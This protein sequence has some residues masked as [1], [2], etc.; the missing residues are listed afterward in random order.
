MS[1]LAFRERPAS[2]APEGLLILHH[3]RGS[4]EN[5]L[6]TLADVLD[7]ERRLHVVTPRAPLQLPGS[8]GYHWYLVPRVG[9]PDPDSFDAA[10]R[11]LG[12]LHDE[13]WQ[14]TGVTPQQ[15]V[16]GG[17]SMGAV[18][19]YVMAFSP[20]RPAPIGVLAFSGFI[21]SVEHWQPDLAARKA[22]RVFIAHG[23]RDQVI[24]VDF[25]RAAAE[26]LR[27]AGVP[28][29]YHESEAGHHIDPR[30]IPAAGAWL[31]DTL[32]HHDAPR[33]P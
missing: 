27:A 13:L 6:L 23:T 12:D 17:F 3:G 22:V 26:Q 11:Q 31:K 1:A 15:T 29:E 9:Y 7:P 33:S 21:A 8:Q 10:R 4:D 2:G 14:R 25:A 5:D 16:M 30:T 24:S 19:S 32:A 20:E 18:M 28:V